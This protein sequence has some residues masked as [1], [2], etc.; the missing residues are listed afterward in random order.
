MDITILQKTKSGIYYKYENNF[1]K[2]FLIIDDNHI[3]FV[4]GKKAQNL[5]RISFSTNSKINLFDFNKYSFGRKWLLIENENIYNMISSYNKLNSIVKNAEYKIISNYRYNSHIN[6]INDFENICK[7]YIGNRS[8]ID[9][10]YYSPSYSP[11]SP[12]YSPES[13]S[14][15]PTSPI[16]FEFELEEI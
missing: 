14:Y 8:N 9:S 4:I 3:G 15:S 7:R 10:Y 2:T 12:T 13:P 6:N 1:Y 11:E 16:E 5:K